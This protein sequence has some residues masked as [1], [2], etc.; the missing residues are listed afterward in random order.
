MWFSDDI[1]EGA[2]TVGRL[3]FMI[4]ILGDYCDKWGMRINLIKTK[5][6]VFRRGGVLKK[7]EKWFYKG[8]RLEV[9]SFYKYLGVMF[10]PKL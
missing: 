2:D 5:I 3:Q 10:T 1:V 9:V 7:C 8:Q 4:N 6:M